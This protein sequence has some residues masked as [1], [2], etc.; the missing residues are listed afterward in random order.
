MSDSSWS[1]SSIFMTYLEEHFLKHVSTAASPLLI[2]FDGHKSHV[3]LTL[4]EWGKAHNIIFYVLPSHTSHV[5]KPFH[6]GSFGPLKAHTIISARHLCERH[7]AIQ[8]TVIML[9]AFLVSL[10]QGTDT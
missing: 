7:N 6:V 10:Q 3:S 4:S 8:S 1:N 9:L 2:L 5:T